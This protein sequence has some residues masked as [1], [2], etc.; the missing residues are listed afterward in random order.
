MTERLSAL[1]HDSADHLAV[2]LAPAPAIISRGRSLRRRS[3]RLRT[4]IGIAAVV[5]TVAGTAFLLPGRPTDDRASVLAPA[6]PI[7]P[8]GWAV[9]QGS[10]IHLGSGATSTV[11]GKVKAMYYTS[12]GVMVRTGRTTSTDA[13]KSSYWVLAPDGKVTDFALELGDRKPG[14]DPTLPYLAYSVAGKDATHWELVLRDVRT[15]EVATRIPYEGSFTWGGWVAPPVALSGDHAY[16]GVDD[17][18]LAIAWRTGEVKTAKGLLPS[19]MPTVAG[20]REFVEPVVDYDSLSQ[21]QMQALEGQPQTYRVV[22]AETGAELRKITFSGDVFPRLSSD[23][24][25]VLLAPMGYCDADTGECHYEKP[26]ADVISVDTGATRE[27]SGMKYGGY[28]WSPDGQLL[29]VSGTEVRACNG[30]TGAC[31]T[32]PV[33]IDGSGSFR[34][35]GNDNES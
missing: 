8:D 24:R 31:E 9:A 25:H 19:R 30:D 28:G 17:A 12:A 27:F 20:G 15:G 16:V 34:I 22:D 35:S 2:P 3:R 7:D 6:V 29:L 1:L 32:T 5:A 23:G 26:T 33:Q 10:T 14:T 13:R 18:T 4:G 11:P 21:E